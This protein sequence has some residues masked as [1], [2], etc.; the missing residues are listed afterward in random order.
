M[1]KSEVIGR[2]NYGHSLII[3]LQAIKMPSNGSI[4]KKQIRSNS[5]VWGCTDQDEQEERLLTVCRKVPHG[6][7]SCYDEAWWQCGVDMRNSS[8]I[9]QTHLLTGRVRNVRGILD[10]TWRGTVSTCQRRDNHVQLDA[11][12]RPG[13]N[14][15]DV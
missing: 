2:M 11:V 1:Y 3:L 15:I 8:W 10:A 4:Q 6:I 9:Q 14:L 7:S 5:Y 12:P 13:K